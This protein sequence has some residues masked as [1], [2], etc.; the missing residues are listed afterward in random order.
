MAK[1]QEIKPI[2][3]IAGK[4]GFLVKN[5]CERLLDELI[6]PEQRTTG[7]WRVEG[8]DTPIT[9]VLDELRTLPFFGERRVAVIE[10]ADKTILKKQAEEEGGD[11]STTLSAGE[12]EEPKE[13]ADETASVNR[14]ILERYFDKP[15]TSGVLV[16][17]VSSWPSNTRLA[18]KL[19]QFG[20]LITVSELNSNS[21]ISYIRNYARDQHNKEISYNAAQE[22]IEFI[23]EEPGMLCSEIDKLAAYSNSAKMIT[24]KDIEAA[25]GHNRIFGVFEVIDSM[26]AGDT[27]KALEKFR[28]MFQSDKKAEYTVLGAFAWHFRRMFSASAMLKNGQG[29]E[30]IARKLRIWNSD[31]FF[32]TLRKM[33]LERIGSCLKRLAEIDYDVKTGRATAET[34]IETMIVNLSEK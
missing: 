33:P 8:R 23:G 20:K 4:D 22:L 1:K 6:E 25:S 7:L 9:N 18:K 17:T 34:A 5:E 14:A 3:V 24:E 12:S 30:T 26:T 16:L 15:S 32:G 29:A 10:N 27:G 13:G 21:L 2:Y 31:G 11:T 19:G 28:L